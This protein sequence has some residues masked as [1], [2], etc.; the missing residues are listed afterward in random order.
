MQ[1]ISSLSGAVLPM[2]LARRSIRGYRLLPMH[3]ATPVLSEL[4][5]VYPPPTGDIPTLGPPTCQV[6]ELYILHFPPRA[7][8]PWLGLYA[9]EPKDF[10]I[11]KWVNADPS[12]YG[13]QMTQQSPPPMFLDQEVH[14]LSFSHKSRGECFTIVIGRCQVHLH[15]SVSIEHSKRSHAVRRDSLDAERVLSLSRPPASSPGGFNSPGSSAR[16]ESVAPAR[17]KLKAR[18]AHLHSQIV[19]VTDHDCP[20]DHIRFWNNAS[21]SFGDMDR[22]VQLT[23]SRW[24]NPDSYCLDIRLCGRIYD[25]LLKSSE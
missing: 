19:S 17:V 24:P 1:D 13:F 9:A 22:R 8:H 11:P 18:V 10:F 4:N 16:T 7:A 2:T 12:R 15:A 14:T 5:G 20:E 6:G 21:K 23:F 3:Y 25:T